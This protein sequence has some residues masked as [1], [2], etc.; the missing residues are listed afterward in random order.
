MEKQERKETEGK[1]GEDM[2]KRERKKVR[3]RRKVSK[4]K[5]EEV[6]IREK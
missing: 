5:E 4:R 6:Y 1:G 2:I 3:D